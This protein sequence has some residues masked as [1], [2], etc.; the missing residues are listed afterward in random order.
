[1][2]PQRMASI[3]YVCMFFDFQLHYFSRFGSFAE[4]VMGV[5]FEAR[6]RHFVLQRDVRLPP[7]SFGSVT[8]LEVGT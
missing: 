2:R 1:M 5:G 7:T 3:V 8:V 4:T 6:L